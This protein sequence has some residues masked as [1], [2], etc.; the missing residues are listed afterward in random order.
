MKEP[1]RLQVLQDDADCEIID[2]HRVKCK[3]CKKSISLGPKQTYTLKPWL[4]HRTRCTASKKSEGDSDTDD[5]ASTVAPSVDASGVSS[6]RKNMSES[7]RKAQLLSDPRA[8]KVEPDSITCRKCQKSIRCSRG[9]SKYILAGWNKHQ[10]HCSDIS[11]IPGHRVATAERKLRLVNDSQAKAFTSKSVVCASC[12]QRVIL[13]GEGDYNLTEWEQHKTTCL[14]PSM[15]ASARAPASTSST[16]GTT[17]IGSEVDVALS[18]PRGV[19]RDRDVDAEDVGEDGDAAGEDEDNEERP[20]NR[21]RTESYEN[22]EKKPG[23]LGWF[24]LPFQEFARGFQEGLSSKT[25]IPGP[26]V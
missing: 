25:E 12:S 2:P 16:E 9:N 8:E 11:Y 1:E 22:S 4:K 6:T 19:K 24:L 14:D 10:E 18:G 3:K 7:D 23:L 26:S 15:E 20:S 21:P 17:A 5:A 13:E